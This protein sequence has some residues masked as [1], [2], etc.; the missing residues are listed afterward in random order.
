VIRN[1][2]LH[3]ANEQPLLADLLEMPGPADV[4]LRLTNLRAMDGKK[5]IFV[6]DTRSVFLFPYHRISF[7]EIPA[8]SV[9]GSDLPVEMPVPIGVGSP[10]SAV[11]AEEEA[12]L[13]IDED[14]LRR[15]REA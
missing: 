9:A 6:D 13:E 8:L 5:P 1:A 15:V 3:I 12:E 4:G 10:A 2:V 14:F 7:I 11:P